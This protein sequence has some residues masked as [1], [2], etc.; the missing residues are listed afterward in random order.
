MQF[1]PK[2]SNAGIYFGICH[3]IDMDPVSPVYVRAGPKFDMR[4]DRDAFYTILILDATYG[5]VHGL[6]VDFPT[7]KVSDVICRWVEKKKSRSR[8]KARQVNN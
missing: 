6:Y 8:M 3:V 2:K 4:T 7:P 5:F 1:F